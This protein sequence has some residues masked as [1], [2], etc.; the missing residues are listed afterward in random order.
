[1]QTVEELPTANRDSLAFIMSHLMKVVNADGNQM[2]SRALA[3][4]FGPT[5]VGHSMI[6]PPMTEILA[7]NPKQIKVMEALFRISEEYWNGLI[8]ATHSWEPNRCND[9]SDS[10]VGS[11]AIFFNSQFSRPKNEK[12]WSPFGNHPKRNSNA[13]EEL[14]Q[15]KRRTHS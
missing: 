5:I 14:G 6:D 8:M 9:N 4:I 10:I 12:Q 3:K 11:L 13:A 1:M 15:I 7:E 2:E